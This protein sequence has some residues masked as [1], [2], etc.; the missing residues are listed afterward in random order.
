MT[1]QS[2]GSHSRQCLVSL[3]ANT[4]A[5]LNPAGRPTRASIAIVVLILVATAVAIIE[6]EPTI[7]AGRDAEFRAVELFF[8]SIFAVEYALRIWV[9]PE[10]GETRT[11]YALRP[12]TIIDLAVVLGSLLPFIAPNIVVLRLVRVIRM[13]RIAKVGRYST[14]LQV[15]ARAIRSRSAQLW[16]TFCITVFF[17]IIS[18][19]VL[20]WIEGEAQPEAFGSIPRSLW[21]ASVTMT[22]VGYGDVI[23]VTP[24]GKAVASLIAL[25]GIALIAIPTGILAA[26]FS[27]EIAQ[28]SSGK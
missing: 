8:G 23:P 13:L 2:H 11:R 9:A 5:A 1:S 20:F 22:T 14:A 7:A 28:D 10:G 24:L 12:A 4:Y 6:T 17:L 18:A 16:V 3:R 26:A 21:W 19:T 27:D 25:S 15:M